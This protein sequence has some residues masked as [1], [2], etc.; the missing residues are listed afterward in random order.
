MRFIRALLFD[1][2]GTLV[3]S[4]ADIAAAANAAIAPLGLAPR[5]MEEVMPH[6][7]RGA[8]YLM[9]A[10]MGSDDPAHPQVQEAVQRFIAFYSKHLTEH[11][12]VY[13]GI[14]EV[15]E[16]FHDIPRL[17]VSNK[18][19][20]LARGVIQALGLADHFA[21]VYGGDSC[22]RK[23]PDP[24]PIFEAVRPLEASLEEV[25]MIGDSR[26]DV[27]AGRN[28]GTITCGVLYGLGSRLELEQAAPDVL[29]SHPIELIQWFRSG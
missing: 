28:A 23:K 21:A 19:E 15:L 27:E 29:I 26:I 22:P 10:L 18:P 20:E 5:P 24:T 12:R 16:H 8:A 14:P 2:D 4:R 7:G 1:L 9:T 11:T 3:D 17:V 6:V 13:P 25:V